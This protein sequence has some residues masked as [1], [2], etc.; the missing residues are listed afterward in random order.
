LNTVGPS[1]ELHPGGSG[2]P[3]LF[4]GGNDTFNLSLNNAYL[5]FQ[6]VAGVLGEAETATGPDYF[7]DFTRYPAG[8]I[9][10]VLDNAVL[11]QNS[12][13]FTVNSLSYANVSLTSITGGSTYPNVGGIYYETSNVSFP[14]RPPYMKVLNATVTDDSVT[15]LEVIDYGAGNL[16]GDFI[17][18]LGGNNN[19]V[20]RFPEIAPGQQELTWSAP[21]YSA[22][23]GPYETVR[24]TDN[25]DDGL[26]VDVIQDTS[27]AGLNIPVAVTVDTP[28]VGADPMLYRVRYTGGFQIAEPWYHCNC[29][30]V[31]K[32]SS[33]Y[34]LIAGG[35]GFTPT[36]SA[37]GLDNNLP[38][39]N[40]TA[41]SLRLQFSNVSNRLVSLVNPHMSATDNNYKFIQTRY[42]F[43]PV[44]GTELEIL[45]SDTGVNDIIKLTGR[46]GSVISIEFIVSGNTYSASSGDGNYIYQ[47]QRRDQVNPTVDVFTEA[48]GVV[49]LRVA[50]RVRLNT[51]GSNNEAND[52]MLV[53]AVFNTAVFIFN[54]NMPTIDL[55]PFATVPNYLVDGDYERYSNVITSS[56][57]LLD[58][59]VLVE[60]RSTNDQTMENITPY[61][62][63]S[64]GLGTPFQESPPANNV[65]REFYPN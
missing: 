4:F 26:R 46:V 32:Q 58:R 34:S 62:V 42:V 45:G 41:N 14:F 28:A 59:Q 38:T 6:S 11:K 23:L 1:I 30:V 7:Q 22:A 40:L 57:N 17:L 19:C 47:T 63:S 3:L 43:D 44:N 8:T 10:R 13:F 64:G 53:L 52:L 29:L 15:V 39:Y 55:P 60:L 18:I 25:V 48:T 24:L 33:N 20:C 61:G 35:G 27:I 51:L 9:V 65:Y 12:A 36:V 31:L 54:N 50:S 5:D 49:I 56:V 2:Y 37:D 16:P 21:N